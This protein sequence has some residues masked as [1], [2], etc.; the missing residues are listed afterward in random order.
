VADPAQITAVDLNTAHIAL[1]NLKFA[2]LR[3]L[4]DYDALRRFFVEADNKA[5]VAAYRQYLAPHLDD[6]TRRYWEGRDLVGRKRISGFANGIYKRGL[7][8]NFIGMAHFVARLYRVD[9]RAILNAQSIE[10]QRRI[11]DEKIA[12]VFDKRFIRWL[13]NQP[14][15]LFGLGIPPAQFDALAGDQRM[16]HVLRA[17]GKAGLR[18]CRGRKLL[19]MAGLQSRL[20][21]RAGC[22][23]PPICNPPI[24][25]SCA[26]AS[27]A[28]HGATSISPTTCANRPMPASTATSFSTHRIG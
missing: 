5:N 16:A 18:L 21:Q 23:L 8:G 14:A 1:G 19:R 25:K 9:L 27:A 11:F 10:D 7:L 2:A 22:P 13:T 12:P 15:S 28:S 3:H 6:A 17:A 26:T 20:W 24:M 4:P